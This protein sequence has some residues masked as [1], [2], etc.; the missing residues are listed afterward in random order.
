MRKC[1]KTWLA[2]LVRTSRRAQETCSFLSHPAP[3]SFNSIVFCSSV[4]QNAIGRFSVR[5]LGLHFKR[6]PMK[7]FIPK[8]SVHILIDFVMDDGLNSVNA[9][10]I[11]V[12]VFGNY[13]SRNW[14]SE[15]LILSLAL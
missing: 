2:Y 6:E 7:P 3:S 1:L 11:D 8:K 5:A 9:E 12:H 4:N 10:N 13:P 15:T 14:S